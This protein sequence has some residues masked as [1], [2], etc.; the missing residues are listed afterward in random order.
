MFV[1]KYNLMF[2]SKNGTLKVMTVFSYVCMHICILLIA[3]KDETIILHS[4]K[5]E[6]LNLCRALIRDFKK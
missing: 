3:L 2:I 1:S 4:N 6:L 5:I